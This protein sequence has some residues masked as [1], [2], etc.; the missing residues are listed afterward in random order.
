SEETAV[1][2]ESY[3]V[4]LMLPD[5]RTAKVKPKYFDAPECM[6]QPHLVDVEQPAV[7]VDTRAKLYEYVVLSGGFSMYSSL[8]SRL[9]KEVKQL[10]LSRVLGDDIS[11]LCVRFLSAIRSAF[12]L[13][14]SVDSL[15]I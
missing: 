2:I 15:A 7:A 8:P 12:Y 13:S 6:F 10:Y 4:H 3:T 1:L 11:T 5:G 9:K 14:P